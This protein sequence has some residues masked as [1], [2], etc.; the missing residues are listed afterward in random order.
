MDKVLGN[1]HMDIWDCVVNSIATMILIGSSSFML[2]T[3]AIKVSRMS[4]NFG[5]IID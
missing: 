4:L 1:S 2:V 5:Q 3:S